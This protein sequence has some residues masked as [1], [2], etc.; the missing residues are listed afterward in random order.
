MKFHQVRMQY[1]N[2]APMQDADQVSG[3]PRLQGAYKLQM[4]ELYRAIQVETY[5]QK[6]GH[7]PPYRSNVAVY[8]NARFQ[9]LTPD[10]KERLYKVVLGYTPEQRA[11]VSG[12]IA[13]WK[14]TA[15]AGA[16]K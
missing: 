8:V 13:N 1:R 2:P 11:F 3:Q 9:K 5:R 7:Y 14:E 10:E 12:V 16:Y 15:L 4:L 6:T